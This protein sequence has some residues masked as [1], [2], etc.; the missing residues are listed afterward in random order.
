MC[1]PLEFKQAGKKLYTR[2]EYHNYRQDVYSIVNKAFVSNAAAVTVDNVFNLGNEVPLDEVDA[3]SS[4]EPYVEF[5]HATG[6]LFSYFKV[7]IANNIDTNSPLGVSCFARAVNQIRNADEQYGATLWEYRS[8]ETAI[9]AGNEFFQKNRKG[10]IVMPKGKERIYHA[11]GDAILSCQKVRSVSIMHWVMCVGRMMCLFLM[12]IRRISETRVFSMVT[13]GLSR[14]RS[15]TAFYR[16]SNHEAYLSH[17]KVQIT[18][19]R[20]DIYLVLVYGITEHP[21]MLATNKE[22]QSKEDVIKVAKLYFSRWKIEE[23]FRCKK[24]MFKFENFRVRKLIAINAL[25]F[26]ITV[27]MAFLALMSMS[28]E[29]NAL[30]VS[31]IKMADPIKEKVH[32]N[33]YRLAKGISGI[34]AYAKEGVR[35]WFRTNRPAYHQICLKLIS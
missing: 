5:Y 33:Y 1:I 14:R 21:M 9:Q 22:I 7:P 18:A 10:D 24:Q 17:V 34:L 23:Y 27:C 32:F 12:S 16:G 31:I 3:W 35:L 25:N 15:L 4:L 28:S 8:K 13:T 30:R 11:L 26:Y 19:S 2:L 20:K 6:P 29:T